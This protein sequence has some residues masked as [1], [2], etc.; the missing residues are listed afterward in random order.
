MANAN[1]KNVEPMAHIEPKAQVVIGGDVNITPQKVRVMK[2]LNYKENGKPDGS[3]SE[4]QGYMCLFLE[5]NI[6]SFVDAQALMSLQEDSGKKVF[7]KKSNGIHLV[8]DTIGIA[9]GQPVL[10]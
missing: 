1:L 2:T 6:I 4:Y 7:E 5:D 9:K 8:V 3:V 10:A